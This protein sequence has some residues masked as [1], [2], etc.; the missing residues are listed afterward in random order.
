MLCQY[1]ERGIQTYVCPGESERYRWKTKYFSA[2]LRHWNISKKKLAQTHHSCPVTQKALAPALGAHT[3]PQKHRLKLLCS[4]A[5]LPSQKEA[6]DWNDFMD[7]W[8]GQQTCQ[9]A[10][11]KHRIKGSCATAAQ[12]AAGEISHS[13][14]PSLPVSPGES[15]ASSSSWTQK[16]VTEMCS[17]MEGW[18]KRALKC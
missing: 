4:S 18:E 11:N 10:V 7:T 2:I 6:S 13:L 9:M 8:P 16:A 3:L 5:S 15:A 12:F 14:P 17:D 1:L